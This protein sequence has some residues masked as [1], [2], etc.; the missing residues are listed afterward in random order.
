V[1]THELWQDVCLLC[2]E[3]AHHVCG[4]LPVSARVMAAPLKAVLETRLVR[5]RDAWADR[6]VRARTAFVEG[7]KLTS[8]AGISV[9]GAAA[10]T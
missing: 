7:L 3:R 9:T 1:P 8:L 6:K 4:C 5:L 2:K 10:P